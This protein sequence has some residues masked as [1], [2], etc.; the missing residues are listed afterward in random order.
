MF[1]FEMSL[2]FEN[3]AAGIRKKIALFKVEK[4]GPKK[5]A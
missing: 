3:E 5:F 1:N 4:M 2:I